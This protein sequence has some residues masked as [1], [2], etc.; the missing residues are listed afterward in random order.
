MC[1]EVQVPSQHAL[2]RREAAELRSPGA[3]GEVRGTLQFISR[4]AEGA[5]TA[6]QGSARWL[7][8]Q[9]TTARAK[10]RKMKTP[11]SGSGG[12]VQMLQEAAGSERIRRIF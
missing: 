3:A 6:K 1:S 11:G 2:D 9:H 5:P 10:R 12:K 8:R 7:E 4:A